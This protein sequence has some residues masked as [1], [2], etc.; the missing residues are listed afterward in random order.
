MGQMQNSQKGQDIPHDSE[1]LNQK[2][3]LSIYYFF[4]SS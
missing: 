4:F 2:V 1:V 3:I